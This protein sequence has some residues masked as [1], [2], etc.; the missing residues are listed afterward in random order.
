VVGLQVCGEEWE[1]LLGRLLPGL[2]LDPAQVH[3]HARARAR[4]RT[5]PRAD[6]DVLYAEPSQCPV[7]LPCPRCPIRGAL[8]PPVR[9]ALSAVPWFLARTFPP[10]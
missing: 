4:A 9:G 7:P 3:T 5:P 2:G 1:G 8:S 10:M 6:R